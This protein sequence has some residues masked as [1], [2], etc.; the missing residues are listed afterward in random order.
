MKA[1]VT[2]YY[3]RRN[4]ICKEILLMTVLLAT[5]ICKKKKNL[6]RRMHPSYFNKIHIPSLYPSL[7]QNHSCFRKPENDLF[8]SDIYKVLLSSEVDNDNPSPINMS[9]QLTSKMFLTQVYVLHF[10][11]VPRENAHLQN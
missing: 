7:R 2:Q 10:W 5:G 4:V 1:D 11:N 9:C 3:L 8:S 6:N